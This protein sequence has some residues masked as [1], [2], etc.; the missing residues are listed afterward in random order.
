M[1]E[2]DL[3]GGV[4]WGVQESCPDGALISGSTHAE[5]EGVDAV[6]FHDPGEYTSIN[7]GQAI[8]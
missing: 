5:A 7:R 3:V 2:R 8:P 1:E 4:V 6:T